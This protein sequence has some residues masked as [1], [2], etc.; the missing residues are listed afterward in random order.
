MKMSVFSKNNSIHETKG[1]TS[2]FHNVENT[3]KKTPCTRV[4]GINY[5]A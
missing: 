1:K 3:P 4:Q 5:F 2:N